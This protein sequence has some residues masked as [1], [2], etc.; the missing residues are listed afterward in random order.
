MNDVEKY[1]LIEGCE[2]ASPLVLQDFGTAE[3]VLACVNGPVAW[4]IV[5][6]FGP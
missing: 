3:I 2:N 1:E 5:W 4:I 6:I